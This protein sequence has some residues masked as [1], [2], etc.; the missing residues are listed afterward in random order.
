MQPQILAT[1]PPTSPLPSRGVFQLAP[2]QDAALAQDVCLTPGALELAAV[3]VYINGTFAWC[4][5]PLL[6]SMCSLSRIAQVSGCASL[7]GLMACL[8]LT[9]MRRTRVSCILLHPTKLR[10]AWSRRRRPRQHRVGMGVAG[11]VCDM[12]EV[13][14]LQEPCEACAAC[15][16]LGGVLGTSKT[17]I[18]LTAVLTL[19]LGWYL[20]AQ[21]AEPVI[22]RA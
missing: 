16:V 8:R 17:G 11:R 19:L 13:S 18:S 10:A 2:D 14:E 7:P 12:Q 15:C 22:R 20:R 9:S 6:L 1:A 3:S 5:R 21:D 4:G